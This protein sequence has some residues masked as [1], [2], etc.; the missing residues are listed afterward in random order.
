MEASKEIFSRFPIEQVFFIVAF[1]FFVVI[2]FPFDI[3]KFF[4]NGFPKIHPSSIF[5]DIGGY[6]KTDFAPFVNV[7]Y[8]GKDF[9]SGFIETFLLSLAFGIA[10]FFLY[11]YFNKVN[12]IPKKFYYWIA[13]K[14][15]K[16]PSSR[17]IVKQLAF[18]RWI[19]KEGYGKLLDFF[20][21]MQLV[22]TGLLWGAEVFLAIVFLSWLTMGFGGEWDHWWWMVLPA[23][24]L[25][26]LLAVYKACFKR[27]VEFNRYLLRAFEESRPID[28]FLMRFRDLLDR[29]IITQ[30]EYTRERKIKLKEFKREVATNGQSTN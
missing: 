6:V 24:I 21:S 20:Y 18:A 27:L 4:S 23:A 25:L 9:P 1:G 22:A 29:E 5:Q 3:F 19:R 7:Q 15:E 11:D 8:L 16:Q 28:E 2:S 13:R 12:H 14:P 17:S 30:E 10:V 26:L